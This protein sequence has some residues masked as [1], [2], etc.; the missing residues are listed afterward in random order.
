MNDL[1][2][3]TILIT[4]AS[5]GNGYGIAEFCSNYFSRLILVDKDKAGLKKAKEKINETKE[6]KNLTIETITCDLSHFSEINLLIKKLHEEN[7]SIHCLVNNAGITMPLK[8]DFQIKKKLKIWEDTL[9]VNLTAPFHLSLGLIDLIPPNIGTIINITSLNSKLAFPNNP[10]YMASKGGLRQLSLSLATDLSHKKIRVNS[11]APGYFKTN[12]TKDSW[13]DLEKRELRSSKTLLN[14]WGSPSELGGLVCF[15][16]SNISSYI[17][18]Q[19]IYVDG[20]WSIKG[21]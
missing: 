11:I 9:K 21:L 6:N 17:T 1:K 13:N 12:M 5:S 3:Y 19:E 4:G 14:R 8:D 18:G 20:G 15:L 2:K 16:A 7:I 10:A